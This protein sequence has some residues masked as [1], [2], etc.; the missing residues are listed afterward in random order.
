MPDRIVA[1]GA[2][3]QDVALVIAI[4]VADP[5]NM[6]SG[7]QRGDPDPPSGTAGSVDAEAYGSSNHRAHPDRL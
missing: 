4:E 5:G 2:A 6:P 7:V 1:V 3:P